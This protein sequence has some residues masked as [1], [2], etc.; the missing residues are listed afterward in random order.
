MTSSF[1]RPPYASQ[2]GFTL[3]EMM[4][5]MTIF[6]VI[7]IGTAGFLASSAAGGLLAASPTAVGAT[8]TA[9]DLT[10]A[11]SYLL[12][13]MEFFADRAGAMPASG[14]Y[15]LGQRCDPNEVIEGTDLPL[16]PSDSNQ[17]RAARLLID[18]QRW[19]WNPLRS[20]YCPAGPECPATPDDES[21]THI[22]ATLTWQMAATARTLMVG[23]LLP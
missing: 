12:A 22:R 4:V 10:A 21:V 9:K 13:V 2:D 6:S 1:F 20:G 7:V 14:T 11:S 3:L 5:A 8:Q 19:R 15:C 18:I 16:L 17:L 23:W